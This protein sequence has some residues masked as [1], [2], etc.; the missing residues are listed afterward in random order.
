[1]MYYYF[2][3]NSEVQ[4]STDPILTGIPTGAPPG[5]GRL[6]PVLPRPCPSSPICIWKLM[7]AQAQ[8]PFQR[9]I[10]AAV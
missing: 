6:Y 2:W 5:E 3:G 1:M 7:C 9:W 4:F 10:F 8:Q